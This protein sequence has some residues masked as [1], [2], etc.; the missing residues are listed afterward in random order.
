[1]RRRKQTEGEPSP[2]RMCYVC[3]KPVL[4]NKMGFAAITHPRC[5]PG[6]VRWMSYFEQLPQGKQTEAGRLIYNSKKKKIEK[7]AGRKLAQAK[8]WETY[9]VL[10]GGVPR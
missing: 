3:G 2:T 1:M 10:F 5:K 7:I 9:N 8:L 4:P 6:T